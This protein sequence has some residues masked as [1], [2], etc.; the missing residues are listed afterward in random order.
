MKGNNKDLKYQKKLQLK[1]AKFQD[2]NYRKNLKKLEYFIQGI[3][4]KNK[5]I[6]TPDKFVKMF[7]EEIYKK[8]DQDFNDFLSKIPEGNIPHNDME[9]NINIPNL[10]NIKGLNLKSI[11]QIALFAYII[12]N[13]A[14]NYRNKYF[15]LED[16]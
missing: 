1:N 15:P 11:I 3:Y 10:S 2:Q 5:E 4:A 6:P 13:I 12:T 14:K 9:K 7:V 8:A 16:K